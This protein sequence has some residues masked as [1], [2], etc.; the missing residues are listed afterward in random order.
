MAQSDG[1]G[2][3]DLF[4]LLCVCVRVCMCVCL[5]AGSVIKSNPS[6]TNIITTIT[7]ILA[8]IFLIMLNTLS[9]ISTGR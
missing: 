4:V 2:G 3:V 9:I 6:K 5:C 1:G 7:I 8:T